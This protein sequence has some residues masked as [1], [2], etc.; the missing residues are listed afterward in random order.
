MP[1]VS[2]RFG[3]PLKTPELKDQASYLDLQEWNAQNHS[4]EG[5]A[6]YKPN[7]FT[8][9]DERQA[10]RVQG[11]RV[12]A[13]FLSVLKVNPLLG[14]DFLVEEEKRGAK[15]VVIVSA[16]FWRIRLAGDAHAVGKER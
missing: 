8:L 7:G 9:L 16:E 11:M 4:F 13:N 15:G 12:T 1:N 14:R 6:G 2:S 5:I 10:E 3:A